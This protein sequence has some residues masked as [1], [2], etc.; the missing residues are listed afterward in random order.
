MV[1]KTTISIAVHVGSDLTALAVQTALNSARVGHVDLISAACHISS[2]ASVWV[3]D[4]YTGSLTSPEHSRKPRRML[5]SN[6]CEP[7]YV[8]QMMDQGFYGYLY[9]GDSLIERLPQAVK[10]VAAGGIYLSPTV[11][12]A[13]ANMEHYT[14]QVQTRLTE[15]QL[16][17][18]RLMHHHWSGGRIAAHLGRTTTAIYQVQRF[19]RDLFEVETNGELLDRA[20]ELG[21]LPDTRRISA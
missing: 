7:Y 14:T 21:I 1:D 11:A 3:L 10:D 8:R 15:Y 13:L 5:L 9:L 17:V 2:E 6:R 16:E 18:L 4:D 20:V 19:L 12:A